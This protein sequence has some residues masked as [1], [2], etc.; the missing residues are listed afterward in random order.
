LV[1]AFDGLGRNLDRERRALAELALHLH[2]A[3]EVIDQR[4]DDRQADARAFAASL[5]AGDDAVGRQQRRQHRRRNPGAG[6]GDGEAKQARRRVVAREAEPNLSCLGVAD[7]VEHQ[8]GQDLIDARAVGDDERGGARNVDDQLELSCRSPGR[9]PRRR[10]FRPARR[11]RTA[12]G[13]SRAAR[14][15]PW[16]A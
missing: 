3:A 16:P 2:A 14:L 15:R 5:G 8:V 9:P 4:A 10:R 6:V 13:A 11:R 1:V 7:R 12:R